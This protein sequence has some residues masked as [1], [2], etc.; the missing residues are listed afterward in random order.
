MYVRTWVRMYV[1]RP[2]IAARSAAIFALARYFFGHF[3]LPTSQ[4]GVQR[5]AL[6]P[7]LT[8]LSP[9]FCPHCKLLLEF[10][11]ARSAA[12]NSLISTFLS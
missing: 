1:S 10:V 6:N 11:A 7:L 8:L 5:E 9:D 2:K 12:T 4:E 3:T